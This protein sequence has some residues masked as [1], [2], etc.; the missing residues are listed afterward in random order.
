MQK[1]MIIGKEIPLE[2]VVKECVF[3]LL[4]INPFYHYDELNKKTE[5]IDGYIYEL[6]D[7]ITFDKISVKIKG[8][9]PLMEKEEVL[10]RRESG[11]K[12]PVELVGGKVKVYYSS[13]YNTYVD[14]FSAESI[15]FVEN[16]EI[17]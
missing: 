8:Q 12:I 3:L 13:Y 14:S 6:V 1:S 10:S 9:R 16:I 15:H 11:E 7:T 5:I 17:F 4:N 2:A